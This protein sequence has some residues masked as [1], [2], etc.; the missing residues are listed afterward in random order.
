MVGHSLLG[1]MEE[2]T[3]CRSSCGP[4][5]GQLAHLLVTAFGRTKKP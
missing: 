4:K 1:K 3:G 5:G 2:V